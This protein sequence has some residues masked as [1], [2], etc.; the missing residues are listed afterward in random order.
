MKLAHHDLFGSLGL[1]VLLTEVDDSL[2][3]DLLRVLYDN[4]ESSFLVI[5]SLAVFLESDDD[6]SLPYISLDVRV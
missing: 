4:L 3:V 6:F 5:G 2:E 1:L